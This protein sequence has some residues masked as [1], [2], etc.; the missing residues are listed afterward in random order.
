MIGDQ[1]PER[2]LSIGSLNPTW[3][4]VFSKTHGGSIEDKTMIY[5]CLH[6]EGTSASNAQ[7]PCYQII[8]FARLVSKPL[9]YNYFYDSINRYVCPPIDPQDLYAE[10]CDFL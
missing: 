3:P 2:G 5:I 1:K 6:V 4:I 7:E 10:K 9:H 8:K